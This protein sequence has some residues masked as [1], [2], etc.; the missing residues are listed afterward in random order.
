VT[1]GK[2]LGG[3]A[4]LPHDGF[5]PMNRFVKWVTDED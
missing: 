3:G 4:G 5:Y 1:L 2:A